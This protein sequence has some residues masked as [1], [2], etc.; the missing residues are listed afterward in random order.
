MVATKKKVEKEAKRKFHH[1][2]ITLCIS[3]RYSGRLSSHLYHRQVCVIL[4]L[5]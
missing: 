5:S 3:S 1:V 2:E 4:I